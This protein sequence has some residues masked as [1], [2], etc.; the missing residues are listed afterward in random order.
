M[1]NRIGK[2][3]KLSSAVLALCLCLTLMPL[4]VFAEDELPA[5]DQQSAAQIEQ[6]ITVQQDAPASEAQ[7]AEEQT[8]KEAAAEPETQAEP[9][10]S[11]ETAE[12]CQHEL[13]TIEEVPAT[14]QHTGL[15]AHR[16][17]T[18]C[19]AAFDLIESRMLTD[20]EYKALVIPIADHKWD[21][22]T[23]IRQ[24]TAQAPGIKRYTCTVCGVTSDEEVVYVPKPVVAKNFTFNGYSL[25]FKKNEVKT[26]PVF[27][28]DARIGRTWIKAAKKQITLNWGVAKNMTRVDGVIILRKT[29]KQ[30]YYTEIGRVAFKQSSGATT[31]WA[32]KTSFVDKTAKKKNTAYT[33]LVVSYMNRGGYEYI[34]NC[35]D[36]SS[37][38]TTASKLKSV[39]TAKINKKSASLQVGGTTKLTLKYSKP[40]KT[41]YK[42]SFR[43]YTDNAK[44]ATVS[45]KGV[46]KATGV[47]TTK[48]RGRLA[49]GHEIACTV[50]VAGAFKPSTPTIRVDSANNNSISLV[51]TKST[52][53]TSYDLYRSDDGLNWKAPVRVNGTS[54]KVTGL[55][56]GHRY[57]FYVIA[58]NDNGKYSAK[59]SNSNVIYQKA[60]VKLRPT[61]LT[62]WPTSKSAKAGSTLAFTVKVASPDGRKANLQM[63]DGSKWTTKKSITLPKGAGTS[64]VKITFPNNWWGKTSQ[65]RLYIP[66]NNTSEELISKT[67]KITSARK[68]QNPAKMV[69]ISDS[70]GKHGYNHYVSKVL[71]SSTSTRAQHVEALIKTAN[72]Y[73]GDKYV[74]GGSGAPGKG[75][76]ASGLVI[77][78][79]Y[80]AG[81]DLWPISPST[82]PSNCVPKIMS[83]K[84]ETRKYTANHVNI[85]RGD[86]IFFYTGK[87]LVG[88]VA[89]YL[90]ND[91]IL[92]ASM[93][94]G[95]VEDSTI[96]E[97]TKPASKGGKYCYTVAGAKRIFH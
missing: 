44:V 62:S 3:R 38:Q 46:V 86:L 15:K 64:S 26:V 4:G 13:A 69:Q 61:K 2:L 76:D 54:K 33:Y 52:Y 24:A 5:G 74:N 21:K 92:H 36:W 7:P 87:N 82:R 70:I 93:V 45:S 94:T 63:L 49:S 30:K 60:V 34:S 65:W 8:A 42:T 77:Q 50:K 14:C 97:L 83:S 78:A 73:K 66:R 88:H 10:T 31:R 96:T 84:L 55:T 89:I 1:K 9:V 72:K 28:K 51:W 79:C 53:A 58:R 43:W 35:S 59:S 80:G 91:K 16:E 22:G 11:A 75:I 95:K 27:M 6:E 41:Y 12:D 56:K 71:V 19:G 18:K 90:G 67:L 29:G 23:I 37:G 25:R 48:I 20:D 39:Y 68:Y 85:N 57:T 40:K 81:V 32:P 47:G 17:C